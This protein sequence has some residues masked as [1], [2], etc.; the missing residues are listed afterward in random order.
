VGGEI[1][2]VELGKVES[3]VGGDAD[4]AAQV[5]E[6]LKMPVAF[7]ISLEIGRLTVVSGENHAQCPQG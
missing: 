7:P 4:A 5:S 1:G 3:M 2:L 6:Q